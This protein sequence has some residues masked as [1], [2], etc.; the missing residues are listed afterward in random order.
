MAKAAALLIAALALPAVAAARGAESDP[1]RRSLVV[2]AVEKASAAVVNVS[3]EQVVERRASPF[4]FP[5]SPCCT[6]FFRDFVHPRP[7]RCT[8]TSLASRVI[9]PAGGTT[10]PTVRAP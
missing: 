6:H 5:P 4:P 9:V 2:Q 10:M 3:T 7:R 1:E 8:P